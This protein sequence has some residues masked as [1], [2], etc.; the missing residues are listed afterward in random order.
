V[1]PDLLSGHWIIRNATSGNFPVNAVTSTGAYN[2]MSLPQ[3]A[4]SHVHTD[5]HTFFFIGASG[6][7]SQLA[8]VGEI[9][10][11]AGGYQPAGWLICDGRWLNRVTYVG[12]FNVFGYAYGGNGADAFALPD[13]RGRVIAG[14]DTMGTIGNANRLYGWGITAA[15]GVSSMALSTNELPVHTHYDY[16]HAHPFNQDPHTHDSPPIPDN[17]VGGPGVAFG[18]GWPWAQRPTSAN[19]IPANVGAGYANLTN[20]GAGAAFSIVQPTL[21]L[22]FI[23]YSGV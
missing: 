1:F 17:R 18:N 2:Y 22:H 12:L 8:M 5:G 3:N 19:Y 20:A 6:A 7:A 21:V 23:I 16:G 10:A 11:F 4:V 15:S 13:L 14:S 9:K